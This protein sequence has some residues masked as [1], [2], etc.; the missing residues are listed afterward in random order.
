[1]NKTRVL[2]KNGPVMEL[3]NGK[4]ESSDSSESDFEEEKVIWFVP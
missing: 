3:R 1:M 2:A 4:T